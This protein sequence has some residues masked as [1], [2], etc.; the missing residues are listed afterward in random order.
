M[1]APERL[2]LRMYNIGFGDCFLLSLDYPAPL[3][4]GRAERHIL[5]DYGSTRRNKTAG[6]SSADVGDLIEEHCDGKLDVVIVSHRHR[7][8]L[9][10]FRSAETVLKGLDPSLVVRSW[11]EAPEAKVAGDAS[12]SFHRSLAAGAGFMAQVVD[13][14]EPLRP[15]G[16][17]GDILRAARELKNAEAVRVL[18]EL[19][20]GDRGEYLHADQASRIGDVAP[21]VAVTVLGPPTPEQHPAVVRQRE[22]DEQY[23]VRLQSAIAQSAALPDDDPLLEA[24]PQERALGPVDWLIKRME[25]QQLH[26]LN[27]IITAYDD[28]LNNTSLVLLLEIGEHKMLFAGDAQIENWEFTLEDPAKLALLDDIDLYKVGHHGS[29]NATPRT[30][31]ERWRDYYATEPGRLLSLLS[32]Y[33]GV[34]GSEGHGSEVPRHSLTHALDR[35]K[36]DFRLVTTHLPDDGARWVE[37]TARTNRRGHYRVRRIL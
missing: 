15:R 21:G 26:Q 16:L 9:S 31:V 22:D 27:R 18:E 28:A 29:R 20:A 10:G 36:A 17:R 37:V 19:A 34:H 5:I 13:V 25:R 6:L 11:T 3:P 23:W 7:D 12:L 1:V 14:L 8:H 33:P 30:L 24:V 32:T 2:R 4:D 35:P